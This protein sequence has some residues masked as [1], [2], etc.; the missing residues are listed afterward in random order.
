[1]DMEYFQGS[2]V[3]GKWTAAPKNVSA[4]AFKSREDN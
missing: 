3:F 1:M 4:Q 2:A